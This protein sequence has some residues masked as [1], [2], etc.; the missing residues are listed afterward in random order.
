M[1]DEDPP[2]ATLRIIVIQDFRWTLGMDR[3]N[4]YAIWFPLQ[5]DWIEFL[6]YLFPNYHMKWEMVTS[7]N[8]R[9]KHTPNKADNSDP[10]ICFIIFIIIIMDQI[11]KKKVWTYIRWN[12]NLLPDFGNSTTDFWASVTLSRESL[13]L[14]IVQSEEKDKDK[15]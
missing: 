6:L 5:R 12:Y 9:H 13:N 7:Q 8:P 2:V 15:S 11:L 3:F 10:C 14:D 4:K 1:I